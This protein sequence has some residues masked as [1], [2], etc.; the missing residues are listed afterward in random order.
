M[1]VC[2][3]IRYIFQNKSTCSGLFWVNFLIENFNRRL[4]GFVRSDQL[5]NTI[6]FKIIH[7]MIIQGKCTMN[8][9]KIDD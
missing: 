2:L 8:A 6:F 7:I 4:S 3:C 9:H 5:E 1:E